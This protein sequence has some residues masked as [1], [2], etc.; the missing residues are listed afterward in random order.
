MFDD[1]CQALSDLDVLILLDVYPAGEAT[2]PGADSRALS[3]GIRMRGLLEPLFVERR[4][5]LQSML[6]NIVQDK[7]ILL[8]MGAGDIGSLSRELYEANGGQIH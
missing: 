5:E 2:I 6:P 4:D 3:R 8:L 7:D 1:F